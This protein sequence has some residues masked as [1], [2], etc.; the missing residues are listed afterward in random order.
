MRVFTFFVLNVW[1]AITLKISYF[2]SQ[3]IIVENIHHQLSNLEGE[4]KCWYQII[5][6]TNLSYTTNKQTKIKNASSPC[7]FYGRIWVCR[8]ASRSNSQFSSPQNESINRR[9]CHILSLSL[10]GA[11]TLHCRFTLPRQETNQLLLWKLPNISIRNCA[12]FLRWRLP[13]RIR[14]SRKVFSHHQ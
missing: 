3:S 14:W 2:S 10:H 7:L 11:F 13:W 9:C 12:S 5:K 6:T 1:Y 4:K 8:N